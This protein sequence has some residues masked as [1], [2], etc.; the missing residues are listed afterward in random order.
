[1]STIEI[2][3]KFKDGLISFM[4]ELIDQFP[5]E[6]DLVIIRIFLKDQISISDVMDNFIYTL[7]K[8]DSNGKKIRDMVGT[9]DEAFFLEHS[10]FDV[11]GKQEVSH[12]KKLWR[13]EVLDDSDKEV[14]WSWIDSFIKLS[15][16]YIKS[17]AN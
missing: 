3:K 15:D 16:K 11:L 2:L 9:R 7:N 10:M 4:D 8:V 6:G 17:K 1:M 13:S 12:F 14:I 5:Q